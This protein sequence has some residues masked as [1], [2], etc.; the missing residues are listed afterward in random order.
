MKRIDQEGE[1]IFSM[2]MKLGGESNYSAEQKSEIWQKCQTDKEL[3]NQALM[4]LAG[5]SER[6][7]MNLYRLHSVIIQKFFADKLEEVF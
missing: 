2:V 6:A 5:S 4:Y 7:E 3:R 1:L